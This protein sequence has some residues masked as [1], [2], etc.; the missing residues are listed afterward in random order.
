MFFI[1]AGTVQ[2]LHSEKKSEGRLLGRQH[3]VQ[4]VKAVNLRKS[5]MV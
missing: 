2:Q 1:P 3:E 4:I 5:V